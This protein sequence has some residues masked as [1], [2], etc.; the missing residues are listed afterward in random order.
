MPHLA[1]EDRNWILARL[2]E[3]G[4]R[5]AGQTCSECKKT[6][7]SLISDLFLAP[8]IELAAQ[9]R[10]YTVRGDTGRAF[11][12]VECQNCGFTKAFDVG[13]LGYAITLP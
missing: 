9:G 6:D 4:V 5:L 7:W 3:R 12:F 1:A 2:I 13:Q 11:V 10:T 8:R